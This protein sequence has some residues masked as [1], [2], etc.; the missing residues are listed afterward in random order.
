MASTLDDLL[1]DRR[2]ERLFSNQN[3]ACAL[4]LWVLQIKSEQ[5]TEMRVVYGRILPYSHSSNGWSFSNND[6]HLV[7]GNIKVKITRLN[8]YIDSIHCAELL[9]QFSAGQSISAINKTLG[10]E[11][12]E[13]LRKQF[14]STTLVTDNLVYRPVAYL[15]NR[16]AHE[17][18]SLSSPH[19]AAGA[20]SASIT[21]ANKKALFLLNGEYSANLTASLVEQLDAETGL[22]FGGADATRFGDLELLVFPTLDDL[23]QNL[24]SV[25]W[26]DSPRAL[27]AC[28]DPIQV[29]LFEKFQFRLSIANDGQIVSSTIA[30]A[31][32]DEEG[33]FEYVFQVSEELR[34]RA[35]S[36]ELEIFGFSNDSPHQGELCCRWQVGYVRE[37]N[38]QGH[39]V[40]TGSSPVKFDWLEKATR[41][42]MSD[43]V[44]AALTVNRG[45]MGFGNRIGGREADPW[46]TANRELSSLFAR[47]NPPKSEGMFFERWS[48]G[49]GEGR[50]QFVEW[51]RS[52]LAKYQQHQI[53][54]FDPYFETAG[55]GLVLICAAM[56]S[57][58][59]VFT[60]LPK[61]SKGEEDAQDECEHPISG[62]VNN[63]IA[64]CEHNRDLLSRIKFCIYGLKEGRLHDRYVLVMGA[65]E[66]PVAGFHL[67]NS[68]QK[69][70]ENFPLLITPIPADVLLQVEQYKST[71]VREAKTTQFGGEAENPAMRLLFDST[72]SPSAPRRYEPLSFI[73]KPGAGSVL[74]VWSGETSLKGLSGGQLRMQMEALGLLRDNSLLLTDGLKNCVAKQEIN[75]KDFTPI[76]EVLGEVLAHS[77]IGDMELRYLESERDFL[78]FL[79]KF[80]KTAFERVHDNTCKELA[81]VDVQFFHMP[82]EVLLRSSYHTRQLF[83]PTKYAALTWSEYFAIRFLWWYAPDCLLKIAEEQISILPVEPDESEAVRLS[84][85]SQIV[86]E[87]SLSI[88]FDISKTQLDTLVYSGQGLLHWLGL[89]AVE[90]Q[91]DT[92]DGL[93]SVLSLLESFPSRERVRALG[94]MVH[95]AAM[96]SNKEEIF[97]DLVAALHKILPEAITVEELRH[98]I[99]SMR[100]HMRQLAWA[101]PWLFRDVVL[102]LLQSDRASTEDACEIWMQELAS[103]LGPLLNNRSRLFD[104]AREGQTTNIASFLF[105]YSS[106]E[107]REASLMVMNDILKRQRRIVQQPLASTSNWARWDDALRVSLWILAFGRWSEFYLRERGATDQNL[108]QLSWDARGF[109]MVRPLEEWQ[110]EG[111]SK[112]G[113]LIAFLE[114]VEGLLNVDGELK[115]DPR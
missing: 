89:N 60:S 59:I 112:Q 66:L 30:S 65:D 33:V 98:L 96:D 114:Q 51:F 87:I 24:L 76:W 79:K 92:Q 26:T 70:A 64:S 84:L 82:V 85:L 25:K 4:Q 28:F 52:L 6:N 43:R 1:G 15:L 18:R 49:D 31:N 110:S 19:S 42:G 21:Q 39:M 10:L 56:N 83:H 77:S 27:S 111:A 57:D 67:S 35:D 107:R 17:R 106:P 46:V 71:L 93:I 5:S 102:P 115:G 90:R 9:R 73:E 29:P 20:F 78:E 88:E 22:D 2:L 12:P 68:F 38:F 91:L 45:I 37:I 48:M 53:V 103:M 80:L 34:E 69:A 44:K 40:G 95:H 36:T 54:I 50:L 74:S 81:T 97:K 32:R 105:A 94:W 13:K 99:D 8:L 72:A 3:R 16:D 109:A 75:F 113:E 11:C 47:L 62:R 41:P 104:R 55:L 86:S 14:G 100:G 63:L 61:L 23:E 101:E 58:Y 7:F 108:E